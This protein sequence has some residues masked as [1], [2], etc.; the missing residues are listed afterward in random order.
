[1]PRI[2]EITDFDDP[3]LDPYARLTEHERRSRRHPEN[4][5][6]IAESETVIRLALQ[7]GYTPVSLLLE[8]DRISGTAADIVGRCGDIP[9]Y[10]ADGEVLEKLTGFALSRGVLSAMK[11]PALPDCGSIL[12]SAR[13]VAVLE[14]IADSTNVGAI[15]RSAAA[16][17]IDAVLVTPSCADPLL[18]RCVRV[19][20]GT[21]FQIP[22]TYIGKNAEDWRENGMELLRSNG[23]TTAAMALRRDTVSIDDPRLKS[24]E[25]LAVILGTE[26]TGLCDSTIDRADYTVKIS[27]YH[28]V[29]SL[30]VA[31][32]AALAF[33]ETGNKN[34]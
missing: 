28:N 19:S 31:A 27:M 17:G 2:T 6:F 5:I 13:R 33:W 25:K 30:N 24:A 4:G 16:L 9:I 22:W 18:R 12:K 11:R 15:I 8:K 32:A 20:M 29:D 14:N 26:G 1:M 34:R 10:T 3:A 21:V 23:F 7:A